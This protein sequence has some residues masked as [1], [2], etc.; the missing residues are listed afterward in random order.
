M[1]DLRV[2]DGKNASSWQDLHL[3]YPPATICK[4]FR[5]HGAHI[6]PKLAKTSSFWMHGGD[7]LPRAG[8]FPSEVPLRM[9]QSTI[10]PSPDTQERISRASCRCRTAENAS[11]TCAHTRLCRCMRLRRRSRARTVGH[12]GA[13]EPVHSNIF[14]LRYSYQ[15]Y[16]LRNK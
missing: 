14:P 12:E 10:L 11:R 8:V 7:I 4:A 15:I 1:H 13:N 5:I 2:S 16:L 9:H 3:V 6:L